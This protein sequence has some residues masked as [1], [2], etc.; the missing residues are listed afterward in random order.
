MEI[1]DGS[2]AINGSS[3]CS[4]SHSVYFKL[5]VIVVILIG[6]TVTSIVMKINGLL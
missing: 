5:V 1:S 3:S 2:G 4:N 6:A